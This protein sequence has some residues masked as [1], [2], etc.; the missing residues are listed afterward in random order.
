MVVSFIRLWSVILVSLSFLSFFSCRRPTEEDQRPINNEVTTLVVPRAFPVL[1]T[2]N[3]EVDTLAHVFNLAI[4]DVYTNVR[5]YKIPVLETEK[6]ALFA[7]IDY[8][9]PWT[10]DIAI[11]ANNGSAL[12]VPTATKFGLLAQLRKENGKIA[13]AGQYWDKVFWLI[14]AYEYYL[15]TG[16]K[17][18]L[19]TAVLAGAETLKQMETEEWDAE[20]QLFRGPAVFGDGVSAYPDYYTKT[21]KYEEGGEWVSDITKW[22]HNP[23]NKDQ[24][25]DKG[26]GLPMFTLSTNAV[27]AKAYLTQQLL[28]RASGRKSGTNWGKKAETLRAAIIKNFW[29]PDSMKFLYL[30]DHKGKD[31]RQEGMGLTL[32]YQFDLV[33]DSIVNKVFPKVHY[34]NAGLPCLWPAYPRYTKQKGQFGRHSGTVWSHIQG[35]W[36][37]VLLKYYQDSLYLRELSKLTSQVFRDKEFREIW[38]PTTTLP[39]GGLQENNQGT[40]DGW[41][42]THRQVWGAT[43]FL[44]TVLY[45]MVGLDFQEDGLHFSPRLLK[46]YE[47]FRLLNLPYREAILNISITGKGRT[48]TS[49]L[50][51]GEPKDPIFP[52]NLKGV[53]Q[54]EIILGD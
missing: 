30:I 26:F 52:P 21:G 18:L 43:G 54:I 14:G 41:I 24:L 50:L 13:I 33:P 1:K 36:P 6:L 5:P 47:N 10:R 11:N 15:Q 34:T 2:N 42:S 31:F 53:H 37:E 4:G 12:F 23:E 9:G 38:H 32:M 39:Y 51:D 19:D 3:G 8:H 48:V 45:G 7:G 22:A 20:K 46:P 29:Q 49:F 25:A 16:D 17:G 44:R 35:M 28:E 27:Y 40:L